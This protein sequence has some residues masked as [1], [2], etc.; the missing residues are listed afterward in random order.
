[1][2]IRGPRTDWKKAK[3]KTSNHFDLKVAPQVK[4]FRITFSQIFVYLLP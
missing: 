2:K 1:M 3:D 4:P